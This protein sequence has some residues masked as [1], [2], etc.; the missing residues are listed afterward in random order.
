MKK[1]TSIRD[2]DKVMD[3][4]RETFGTKPTSKRFEEILAGLREFSRTGKVRS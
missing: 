3:E 2:L 1:V 4:A